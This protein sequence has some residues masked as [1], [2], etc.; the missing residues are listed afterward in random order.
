VK[1][2]G[3][4]SYRALIPFDR[5]M[6][7]AE[8]RALFENELEGFMVPFIPGDGLFGGVICVTYPCRM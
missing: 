3:R 1:K 8:T 5:I 7:D 4:S 6:K 2:T